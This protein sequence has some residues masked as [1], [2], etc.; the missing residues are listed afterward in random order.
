MLSKLVMGIK[1]RGE[2]RGFLGGGGLCF[3]VVGLFFRGGGREGVCFLLYFLLSSYCFP[4]MSIYCI[5]V[6]AKVIQINLY[7][8][9]I[10]SPAIQEDHR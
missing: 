3:F 9:S 8:K 4:G 2:G 7:R 1:G 10:E 5:F 6:K